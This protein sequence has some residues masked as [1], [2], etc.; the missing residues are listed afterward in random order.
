MGSSRAMDFVLILMVTVHRYHLESLVSAAQQHI[1]SILTRRS[2]YDNN[3]QTKQTAI[4]LYL[5]WSI[6]GP[7]DPTPNTK[8]KANKTKTKTKSREPSTS[9]RAQRR[10]PRGASALAH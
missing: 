5:L 9:S 6:I 2:Y 4:H 8:N 7:S 3:T 10:C 1:I